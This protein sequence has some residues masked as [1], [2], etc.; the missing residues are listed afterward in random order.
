MQLGDEVSQMKLGD[1]RPF[2]ALP[3]P[4]INGFLSDGTLR[5]GALHDG[6]FPLSVHILACF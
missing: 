2:I 5:P 1:Q 4:I 3:F 6:D